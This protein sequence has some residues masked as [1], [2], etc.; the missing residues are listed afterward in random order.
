M[1]GPR[2]VS[3]PRM[4]ISRSRLGPVSAMPARVRWRA[5]WCES[6]FRRDRT[7]RSGFR[8][9]PTPNP[10]E[11]PGCGPSG[12]PLGSGI[13][14]YRQRP[15]GR[16]GE[17]DRA[18]FGRGGEQGRHDL[19]AVQCEVRAGAGRSIGIG[20]DEVEG[21]GTARPVQVPGGCLKVAPSRPLD[22]RGRAGLRRELSLGP[23]R[24]GRPRLGTARRVLPQQRAHRP[25]PLRRAHAFRLPSRRGTDDT[26]LVRIPASGSSQRDDL[27]LDLVRCFGRCRVRACGARLDGVP[28][29]HGHG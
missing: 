4:T 28:A 18:S 11:T 13:E 20:P 10:S 16:G 24:P 21:P 7:W 6:T 26:A 1:N 23:A 2:A 22:G 9:L 15:D 3:V 5:L 14:R 12:V 8:R 27:R 29:A 17:V 25:R 19:E